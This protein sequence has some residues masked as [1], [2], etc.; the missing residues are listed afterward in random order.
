MRANELL[1]LLADCVAPRSFLAILFL[2]IS[3]PGVWCWVVAGMS[4]QALL[5]PE[6]LL[7]AAGTQCLWARVGCTSTMTFVVALY[8]ISQ[9]PKHS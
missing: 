6:L 4:P 8:P 2:I 7:R 1:Q 5:A 9:P 3:G